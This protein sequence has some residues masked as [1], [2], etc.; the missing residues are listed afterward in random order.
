MKFEEFYKESI[1]CGIFGRLGTVFETEENYYY[2]D[3]G[4]GKIARISE[5]VHLISKTLLGGADYSEINNLPMSKEGLEAAISEIE[6]GIESEHILSAKPL[7]TLNPAGDFTEKL[8]ENMTQMILEV[9]E[10]CNL[11]C[12]YCIYN[13]DHSDFRDFGVR[14]MS[15]DVAKKAIDFMFEH[16]SRSEEVYISFY[17]GE[18]LLRFD[19]IKAVVEYSRDKSLEKNKP[20]K[21]GMTTNATLLNDEISD[22]LTLNDFNMVI[23]IDGPKELHDENRVFPNGNGSFNKVIEGIECLL[24]ARDKAGRADEVLIFSMVV[25][26][27]HKFLKYDKIQNFLNA[28]SEFPENLQI[29]TS[30]AEYEPEETEY[31]TPQGA[32]ERKM[33]ED[34]VSLMQTWHDGKPESLRKKLFS[35][36]D[37]EKELKRIHD[38][39][40]VDEPTGS[41]G[42]NGCCLPGSRRVY[43][44]TQ[45][46]FKLCEKVGNYPAMGNVQSGFDFE[47]INQV[48]FEDFTN[49][50]KKYCKDCW[51]VNLCGLCYT[52]CFDENGVH[53]SYRFAHCR[54]ERFH[55]SKTLSRYHQ[56]LERYPESLKVLD[57]ISIS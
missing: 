22:F 11:R 1:K 57:D 20:L 54:E 31:L 53:M 23:S 32:K 34:K 50:A 30:P 10:N 9:T 7:K 5:N 45:G 41:Y 35:V 40:F 13:S 14:S 36:G 21:F 46:D 3:T 12:K 26:G 6:Q 38:R 8:K 17:G 37:L 24:S 33:Y 2:Y 56:I 47:R 19:F 44:T 25:G 27:E 51:A 43:V 15:I 55:L 28:H 49:E 16:S 29:L 39:Y 48:Y 18:P 52:D 42:M 4:T